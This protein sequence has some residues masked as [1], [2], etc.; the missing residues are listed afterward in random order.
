[1]KNRALLDLMQ[2]NS[3]QIYHRLWPAGLAETAESL[4]TKI[5]LMSPIDVGLE[6]LLFGILKS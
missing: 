4:N 6:E 2:D 3:F 1:M 5:L